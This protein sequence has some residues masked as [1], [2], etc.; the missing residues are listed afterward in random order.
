[1]DPRD[2]LFLVALTRDFGCPVAL[3]ANLATAGVQERCFTGEETT[4][5]AEECPFA[6]R[7]GKNQRLAKDF[8][9]Y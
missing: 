1:M 2:A 5:L 3:A 6:G 9:V 8:L 7:L 4:N